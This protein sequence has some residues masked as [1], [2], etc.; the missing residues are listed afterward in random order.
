MKANYIT[1]HVFVSSGFLCSTI[2][3]CQIIL[4]FHTKTS[5]PS[6]LKYSTHFCASFTRYRKHRHGTFIKSLNFQSSIHVKVMQL[7]TNKVRLKHWKQGTVGMN[8]E[9][10]FRLYRTFFNILGNSIMGE[11]TSVAYRIYA[12]FAISFG[13]G[14]WIRQVIETSRHLDNTEQMMECARIA[15]PLT[16]SYWT[17]V[18]VRWLEEFKF[19]E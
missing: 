19:S 17:D 16:T 5:V 10:R 11:G 13:Y 2:I 4:H 3:R 14:C 18:F 7:S 9:K 12:V 1:L 6:N 8:K 15:M